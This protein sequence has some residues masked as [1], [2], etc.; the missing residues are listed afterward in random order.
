MPFC[1]YGDL[2]KEPRE[3]DLGPDKTKVI[4]I[5]QEMMRIMMKYSFENK[6]P[7]FSAA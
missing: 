3:K 5:M 6:V 2:V 7:D 1:P 4:I